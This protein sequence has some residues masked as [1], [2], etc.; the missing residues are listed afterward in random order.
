MHAASWPGGRPGWVSKRRIASSCTRRS[1]PDNGDGSGSRSGSGPRPGSR[2]AGS[3]AASARAGRRRARPTGAPSCTDAAGSRTTSP[4]GPSSTIRPRYMT[5]IR[6]ANSAAVER[7]CV[8]IRTASPLFR[9]PSRSF[10]T[11]ARTETSSIETGSSAT[12]SRGSRTSARRDRDPL[13]LPAGQLVRVAVEEEL[14]RRQLDARERLAHPI[15]ALLLRAAEPVDEERLFDR[16]AHAKA[17]VE[18]L[19]RD[20]G[21]RSGSRA[22][23]GGA[24]AAPSGAMSRPS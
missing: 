16:V 19:V 2:R 5:A 17:R 1:Q 4:A 11:P 21:R 23:A 9:S 8:I 15:E 20:P 13:A 6:S 7:S 3:G 22:A 14:R 18:R 24:R 10:R 12:S